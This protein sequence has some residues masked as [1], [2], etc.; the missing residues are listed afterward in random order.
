[1][2]RVAKCLWVVALASLTACFEVEQTSDTGAEDTIVWDTIVG[3]TICIEEVS[4]LACRRDS[5]CADGRHCFAP[6]ER[7]C[8]ICMEVEQPCEVDENC[9]SAPNTI[10]DYPMTD[11]CYCNVEKLCMPPCG[12]DGGTMCDSQDRPTCLNGHCVQKPC[13]TD[14]DCPETFRC[15]E[16][17]NGIHCERRTCT[18]DE[19]CGDCGWCVGGACYDE[20]GHCD[21]M[22]P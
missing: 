6:G 2:R 10:C 17:D 19:G 20:P 8:G 1:M 16:D 4:D 11:E 5:D 14:D 9:T 21:Y 18:G 13:E 15:M 3:E 12:I 7:N 22:A